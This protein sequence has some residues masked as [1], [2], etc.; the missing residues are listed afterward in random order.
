MKLDTSEVALAGTHSV[1]AE[2]ELVE[3]KQIE[4][5]GRQANF[6]DLFTE[7]KQVFA[8]RHSEKSAAGQPIEQAQPRAIQMLL[9][10]LDEIAPGRGVSPGLDAF[11][12]A[13]RGVRAPLAP[14]D[15]TDANAFTVVFQRHEKITYREQ[16]DFAAKGQVSTQ[17]G[18]QINFAL[19]SSLSRETSSESDSS[20][21]FRLEK[22]KDPLAVN[23]DGKGIHLTDE[24]TA[25]DL[26]GDGHVVQI[27]KLASGSGFL[28]LDAN[29]NGK[30]DSGLELFGTRSGNGF[31][32]LA[33]WDKDHNGWIDE[34]DSV[35]GKLRV[36]RMDSPDGQPLESLRQSGIGAIYLGNAATEFTHLGKAGQLL[37]QLRA[38]GVFLK[39]DGTAGVVQQ[40][41]LAV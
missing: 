6:G 11:Q 32:D 36:W 29:G 14:K 8:P 15:A 26:E 17:D 34:N 13:C 7:Q 23:L 27:P 20:G 1:Q 16:A 18:R 39:E 37:G 40:I 2:Q 33:A 21:K 31:A 12:P 4:M 41:D 25:F 35:Y 22:L 19:H 24:R 3:R 9:E 30:V 10:I 38:S 28:V 5:D